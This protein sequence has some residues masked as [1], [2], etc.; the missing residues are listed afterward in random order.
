MR[1]TPRIIDT[2]AI[3]RG[4]ATASTKSHSPVAPP[5]AAA[6]RISTATRSTSS[7]RPRTPRGV[8]RRLA[9]RRMGPWRGGS[10]ATTI[11]DGTIGMSAGPMMI[12][13]SLEKRSGW[14]ATWVMSACFVTAQKGRYPGGAT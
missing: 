11:T 2:T 8:K 12:P 7:R 6:S 4:A 5:V 1:G 3:G 9:K 13:C 10:I 14:A